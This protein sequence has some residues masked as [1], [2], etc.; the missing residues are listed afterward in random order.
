[1]SLYRILYRST[2]QA[3]GSSAELRHNL[4]DIVR[5]SAAANAAADLTGALLCAGSVFIQIIE[6]PM[7]PLEACFERICCD[8]RH[9]ELRLLKLARVDRRVFGQWPMLDIAP[10]QDLGAL[11]SLVAKASDPD[12]LAGTEVE[13]VV[14]ALHELGT[15][16]RPSSMA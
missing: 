9:R 3:S 6:G 16:Q 7:E 14:A 11:A 5:V 12:R 13:A 2:A 10:P 1:M 8:L 4:G 15:R